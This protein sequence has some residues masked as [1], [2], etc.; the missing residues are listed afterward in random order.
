MISCDIC[1]RTEETAHRRGGPS[2][3]PK[4]WISMV[5]V[6]NDDEGL[7][8]VNPT[9]S[10]TF[11]SYVC[12]A[13][14]TDRAHGEDFYNRFS[15][16]PQGLN[17]LEEVVETREM[18]ATRI[19]LTV[20]DII[21]VLESGEGEFGALIPLTAGYEELPNTYVATLARVTEEDLPEAFQLRDAELGATEDPTQD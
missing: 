3:L 15:V 17:I 13:A 7:D 19:G 18:Q 10:G 12:W 20:L 8:G 11:C 21:D 6:T 4:G 14:F 5:S 16:R 9:Y 2:G 1:E